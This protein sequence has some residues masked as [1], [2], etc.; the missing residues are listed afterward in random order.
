MKIRL[1]EMFIERRKLEEKID[2]TTDK[3]IEHLLMC[4]LIQD[5]TNNLNHWSNE[6][7]S[8]LSRTYSL[9]PNNKLPS[10]KLLYSF[11]IDQ[12]GDILPRWVRG[13]VSHINDKENTNITDYDTQLLSDYVIKYYEWLI[14]ILSKEG[15]VESQ[16]VR[17]QIKSLIQEYN[18]EIKSKPKVG[19]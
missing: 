3:L 18:Q 11:T 15:F 2:N 1:L 9:K 16:E 14:P 10:K 19:V 13:Y 12:F 7:Y 6:V 8:S 4:L 5:D 17:Q